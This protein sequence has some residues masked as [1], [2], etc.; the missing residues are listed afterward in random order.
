L[1]TKFKNP[2]NHEAGHRIASIQYRAA[3]LPVLKVNEALACKVKHEPL[4]VDVFGLRERIPVQ[5]DT[6]N[7][8]F[9]GSYSP[10]KL[11]FSSSHLP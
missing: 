8:P 5:F 3:A 4:D 7:L 2:A 9:A 6:Q 11:E 1:G 10:H